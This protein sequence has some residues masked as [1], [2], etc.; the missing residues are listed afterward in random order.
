MKRHLKD[1][2]C[3]FTNKSTFATYGIIRLRCKKILV[4]TG[5]NTDVYKYGMK[6]KQCKVKDICFI[7]IPYF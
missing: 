1:C 3:N 6:I 2:I 4:F 5:F 7:F